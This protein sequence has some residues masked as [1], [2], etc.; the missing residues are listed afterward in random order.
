MAHLAEGQFLKNELICNEG[1]S[2]S[3]RVGTPTILMSLEVGH[4]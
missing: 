3:F 4:K 1:K 2:R